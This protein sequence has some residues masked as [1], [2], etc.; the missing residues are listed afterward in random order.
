VVT[1]SIVIRKEGPPDAAGLPDLSRA[2]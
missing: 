2:L 1:G